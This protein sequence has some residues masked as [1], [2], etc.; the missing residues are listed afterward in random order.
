MKKLIAIT[1]MACAVLACSVFAGEYPD[2]SVSELEE[3]M[4]KKEVI[5]LD[6]NGSS[7]YAKGHIPGAIDFRGNKANIAELLGDDKDKLVVAYCGGPSCSAYKAGA[8]AAEKAG[9]ANIKHLSIGISG[10]LQAGK[11]TEKASPQS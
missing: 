5:I 1:T 6:V 3:A 10:W 7:S 9:F 11:P 2:I 4:A 8:S